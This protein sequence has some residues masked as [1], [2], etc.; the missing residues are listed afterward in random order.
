MGEGQMKRAAVLLLLLASFCTLA[1]SQSVKIDWKRGTKFSSFTTYTWGQS[2]RAAK[3]PFWHQQVMERVDS[4]LAGKGMKKVE[5]SGN[6]DVIVVYSAVIGD[7]AFGMGWEGRLL[8]D[9]RDPAQKTSLWNGTATHIVFD[10]S[11]KNTAELQKM[12][13]KTFRNYPP[14]S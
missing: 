8:I 9:I 6:P 11:H 13:T 5:L 7:D 12:I 10:K 2:P 3:D 1:V 14:T 4:A